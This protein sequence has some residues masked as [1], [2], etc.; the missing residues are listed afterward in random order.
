MCKENKLWKT[1]IILIGFRMLLLCLLWWRIWVAGSPNVYHCWHPKL[2]PFQQLK[3][4]P[5]SQSSSFFTSPGECQRV[6]EH[7]EISLC[8]QLW[9]KQSNKKKHWGTSSIINQLGWTHCLIETEE[10]FL[11]DEVS[12]TRSEVCQVEIQLWSWLYKNEGNW[13]CTSKHA[14]A[15][16]GAANE[17]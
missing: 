2:K 8:G 17:E 11:C 14:R 9:L 7:W 16:L 10:N 4:L 6:I 15:E 12:Q 5:E 13:T 1:I 3:T